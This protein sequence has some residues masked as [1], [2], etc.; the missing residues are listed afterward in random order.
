[1]EWK[2]VYGEQGTGILTVGMVWYYLI[3]QYVYFMNTSDNRSLVVDS[4]WIN[5]IHDVFKR[6][7]ICN[8]SGITTVA[9]IT[10]NKFSTS[11]IPLT[12]KKNYNIQQSQDTITQLPNIPLEE[13]PSTSKIC[14]GFTQVTEGCSTSHTSDSE[15]DLK[16]YRRSM[17]EEIIFYMLSNLENEDIYLHYFRQLSSFE[18]GLTNQDGSSIFEIV[19]I[20]YSQNTVKGRAKRSKTNLNKDPVRQTNSRNTRPEIL[21]LKA[22]LLGKQMDRIAR[23]RDLL[24]NLYDQNGRDELYQEFLDKLFAVEESLIEDSSTMTHTNLD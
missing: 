1:M 10:D 6:I 8:T 13:Q 7:N 5:I 20:N 15:P 19:H 22:N 16:G 9:I 12:S 4:G 18:D 2:F 17:G 11:D 14:S 24:E 21:E 23:R 3:L